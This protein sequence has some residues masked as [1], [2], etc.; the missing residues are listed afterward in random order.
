MGQIKC[1]MPMLMW[2][3]QQ[4]PSVHFWDVALSKKARAGFH[5]SQCDPK[6]HSHSSG[7]LERFSSSLGIQVSGLDGGQRRLVKKERSE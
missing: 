1:D 6:A 7:S 3:G 5:P 4:D 2:V